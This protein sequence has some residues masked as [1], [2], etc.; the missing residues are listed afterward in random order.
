MLNA[1]AEIGLGFLTV[2]LLIWPPRNLLL[3]FMVWQTLR[4]RY[5]SPD[6]ASYHRQVGMLCRARAV[7]RLEPLECRQLTRCAACAGV[8]NAGPALSATGQRSAHAAHSCWLGAKILCQCCAA[9]AA[10]DTVT[11]SG[12]MAD[13]Q[14][15]EARLG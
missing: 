15:C 1:G 11:Y 9:R 6:A 2:L 4:M 8:G 5:W 3:P 14:T 7:R 10:A 13:T 12:R